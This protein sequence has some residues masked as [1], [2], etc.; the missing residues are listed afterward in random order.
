MIRKKITKIGALFLALTMFAGMAVAC[1]DDSEKKNPSETSTETSAGG[2]TAEGADALVEELYGK[3]K[4]E[5]DGQK[6]RILAISPGEHWYTHISENANEVWFEDAGSDVFQKAIYERNY[7]T[8]KLLGIEISEPVWGGG[9][10]AVSDRVMQDATAGIDEYD[11][12]LLPLGN[13]IVNAQNG[14]LLNFNDMTTFDSTHEWWNEQLVNDCT[15]FG[16]KLYTISGAINI[17]DDCSTNVL[18][19]NKDLLELNNSTIPYQNVFDGTWTVDEFATRIHAVTKDLNGDQEFDE[20]DSWGCGTYGTGILFGLQGFGSGVARMGSE[21]VPE[22]TANTEENIEKCKKWFD[23]ISNSECYYENGVNGDEMYE[24]LFKNG[25]IGFALT[26]LTHPFT[27]RDME[28]DYGILPLPKYNTDQA[29]YASSLNTA[30][31]TSYVIPKTCNDPEMAAACLEVM[32]GYS[33]NTLDRSLHEILFESKLTRDAESREILD[34]VQ[35]TI[36]LDWG[37]VGDWTGGIGACFALHQGQS[38]NM[39]STIASYIDVAQ[40]GL[41]DMLAKFDAF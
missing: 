10:D 28:D 11:L 40:T 23:D 30:F 35:E 15:L 16:E 37:S 36:S 27:L 19:F 26:N 14:C 24:N 18:V 6:L 1:D 21:G 22:I 9:G 4:E 17:W 5:Y 20:E 33:V 38:F 12:A 34:I 39:A 31:C 41:D 25:Q 2:D 32:S 8:Q 29:N 13:A 7:K 3:Y